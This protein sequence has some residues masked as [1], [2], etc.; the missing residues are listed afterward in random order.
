MV[1]GGKSGRGER[2]RGR[3]R[4]YGLLVGGIGGRAV[5][6]LVASTVII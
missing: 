2:G 4:G 6:T 1:G 3:S 5:D